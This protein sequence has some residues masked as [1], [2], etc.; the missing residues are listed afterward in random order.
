MSVEYHVIRE[1]EQNPA[2]TQ[3]TLARALE[4]SLGKANYVLVGLTEKGLVKARKLRNDPGTIRWRYILTP[5]GVREK[6][7]ITREYLQKRVAE[8]ARLQ[9]EIERLQEE[10]KQG[11]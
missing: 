7:R 6:V 2:H 9:E 1:L 10:V 3:R 11:T 8:Y 5:K 4:I